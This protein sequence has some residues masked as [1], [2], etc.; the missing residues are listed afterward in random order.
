MTVPTLN[1]VAEFVTNGV[2]T[3][4]PF[5][6]K[7]L[8]N[9]DLVVSY[10]NPFGT[11]TVL[12]LGTHYTVNGAGDEDGGSIVTTTA[13]AGP[14]QLVVSRE[15][16]AYQQ[17]SLRNQG[18]FLAETHED[19][20]DRLTMLIQQGFSIFTRA[21]VRPFGKPY[22]DAQDRN[23]S[24]LHDP[25]E[26]QDATTK[27]WVN[28]H[29]ADLIDQV[30][31]LINT[32][33]GI[34][35]DAGTLFDYLR[36][37]VGRNVDT[38]A[39]L[40]ALSGARNRRAFVHGYYAPTDGGGGDYWYDP[41]DTLS[42]DNGG[43]IIVAADGGRWKLSGGVVTVKTFGAKGDGVANDTA[44]IQSNYA[45]LGGTGKLVFPKGIYNYTQLNFDSATGLQ[46]EGDG[47]ISTT[48]LRC[49]SSTSSD[50]IKLRSTFD[51][52]ASYIT[53]DHSSA[54]FTGY[55]VELNHKPSSGTDTQGMFFFR[56]TFGSQAFNKFT[57]KG[58]NLDKATLCTFVGCKFVSLLRPVDG[59]NPAGG[60]Y[61]NG[62]RFLQC[63][64]AENVG[65]ALNHLGEQWTAQDCNFQAST[66]G[67]QRIAFSASPVS[68]Q[69][70]NFIN[71]GVYDALAAGSA[72]LNLGTGQGLNV[73]G[74]MWGGRSD[75][76]SSTLLN[77]TG[78]IT[79][80]SFKTTRAS[81]F[82]NFAVAGIAGNSGWDFSGGNAFVNIGALI[83]NPL[84]VDGLTFDLNSP[85]VSRGTLPATSGANSLR[86]NQDGSMEMT[87]FVTA[88]A[89]GASVAVPFPIANFPNACWDVQLT[90][91]S[92]ATT[93]NVPSLVG[94]PTPTGFSVFIAGTG[95]STLRWRAIGK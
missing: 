58:V 24:N 73:S 6:F 22:Y 62:M 50:G 57:A 38:I 23:I 26:L 89:A 9:E 93:S 78:A 72:Y 33:T 95:N 17:T 52:T 25:V 30:T 77:A 36:F 35:Y 37:G 84:N 76:G 75:L 12:T 71:C 82:T 74:G 53:F 80:I 47:A 85:N 27:G 16:D 44:A 81:L 19:V 14:G 49:T 48:I 68:W 39:A 20:F 34:I 13:L 69:A 45:W 79:G 8:A 88:V 55:L 31:G 54:S 91:Q 32:T 40:K 59:Q 10:V 94:S 11:V 66:D 42:L 87:G 56:C 92:P 3:N 4:F 90:L 15:M 21:L 28:N 70:L 2:T 61:S 29:F 5:F 64:F 83:V 86:Y 46:I 7:F 18:K 65:Y 67:A 51:C 60:S 63:Q 1:S 43:T 41:V